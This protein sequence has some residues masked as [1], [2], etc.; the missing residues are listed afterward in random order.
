MKEQ[1]MRHIVTINVAQPL[2][3]I[4]LARPAMSSQTKG[5]HLQFV[6]IYAPT[7][8]HESL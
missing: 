3:S 2:P 4:D 1:F 6:G 8:V 5:T 7:S